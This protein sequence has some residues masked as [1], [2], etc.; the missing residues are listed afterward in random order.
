MAIISIARQVAAKGDEVAEALAKQ[1]G[2]KFITRKEIENRIKE[3]GF[4]ESKMPKYDERKPGFFASLTK[5]RDEYLNYAQS[6]ILEAASQKNVVIIGRGA[7]A[8]LHDVPNNI[9]IRLISDE[10]TRVERLMKEFNWTE[11]QALQRIHESDTN[12]EGFHSS[13][14]N[15]DINDNAMFHAVLNT[16]LLSDEDT[17]KIIAN[18]VNQKITNETENAGEKMIEELIK[19]QTVVNKLSHE[20]HINIEF[21]HASI[22]DKT[23]IL[24]GVSDSPAVVE[25]A[26]QI[27]KK[28]MPGYDSSSAVS[29][30]HNF[31]TF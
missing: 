14:Y 30:V 27:I 16:S 5:D 8:V 7:F 22:E 24:H 9:S 19:A 2:Y 6:A 4:P 15:V 26:L 20:Y 1:L 28:E 12:R 11:T 17:A 3:L 13:F 31:K 23:I 25:E 21:M 18:I 29:I 10:K